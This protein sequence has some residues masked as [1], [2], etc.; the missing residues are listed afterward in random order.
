MS[1]R[2][3]K[4][5]RK[6]GAMAATIAAMTVTIVSF[7]NCAPPANCGSSSSGCSTDSSSTSGSGSTGSSAKSPYQNN[8]NLVIGGGGSGGT[9]TSGSGSSGTIV[10]GGGGSSGSG[11]STGGSTSSG[12][13]T[14]TIVV[15]G[16]GATSGNALSIAKQPQSLSV[17]EKADFNFEVSVTG[18][19]YPYTYQWYKDGSPVTSGLGT[20]AFY[21]DNADRWAKEGVY[22]VTVKDATGSAVTSQ[23]VR[24]GIIE[25]TTGCAAGSYFTYTNGNYDQAYGYFPQYFDGPRGKFIIH[26]S[27]DTMNLLYQFAGY[28]GLKSWSFPALAHLGKATLSCEE[29]IPRIQS[30][31]NCYAYTG[32]VTFECHNNKL[33]MIS[34]TCVRG[35]YECGGGGR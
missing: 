11:S 1:A 7:Q 35:A 29:T 26:S 34:N 32:I 27:Y 33:K 8:S 28:A 24:L 16:G 9:S 25:P 2:F 12:G 5:N 14:G 10:V 23:S 17:Y 15:G 22:S 4:R 31:T 30:P 6:L 20:Y 13:G 18:G 19:K 21:M 3:L